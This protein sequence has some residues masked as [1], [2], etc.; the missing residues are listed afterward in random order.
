MSVQREVLVLRVVVIVEPIPIWLELSR[1]CRCSYCCAAVP[2]S[3]HAAVLALALDN[4]VPVPISMCQS[5]LNLRRKFTFKM[6]HP[7]VLTIF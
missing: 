5:A 7:S 6:T 1:Y 2:L 3:Y 4:A